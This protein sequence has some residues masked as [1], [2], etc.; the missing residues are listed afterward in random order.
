MIITQAILDD[1]T[2][3]AQ[4][5][6][7]LRMNFDLRNSEEDGSQRM[8]NAIEP[9]SPECIHR[10]RHT[11]ETVVCIRGRVMEK[12]YDELKHIC[13]DVIELSPCGPN[14]AVNIPAG[15]WHSIHAVESGSVVLAVKNGRWESLSKEDILSL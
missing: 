5:S 11:S 7:R 4:N 9:G 8:L 6:P 3:R 1:L 13:T 15:Q 10:H 2:R 12:F 14:V